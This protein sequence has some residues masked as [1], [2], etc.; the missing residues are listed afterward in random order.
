M[1]AVDGVVP[2]RGFFG[3]DEEFVVAVVMVKEDCNGLDPSE[4][5]ME[6]RVSFADEMGVDVEV[7]VG[8]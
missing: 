2:L 1:E 4:V 5:A 3:S 6:I 8:D 7:W